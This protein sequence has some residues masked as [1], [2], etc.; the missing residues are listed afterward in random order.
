MP[1]RSATI[2]TSPVRGLVK[3]ISASVIGRGSVSS[4]PPGEVQ[5]W[6]G[7]IVERH[8]EHGDEWNQQQQIPPVPIVMLLWVHD[9]RH[10]DLPG[11]GRH[12][13]ASLKAQALPRRNRNS[14]APARRASER[15]PG[16]L[17]KTG[18]TQNLA[19]FAGGRLP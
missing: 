15:C 9:F 12:M 19:L 10:A 6:F 14:G 8:P 18:A 5:V 7:G 4:G 16:R 17:G 2:C 1:G 11:P 13:S 3:V